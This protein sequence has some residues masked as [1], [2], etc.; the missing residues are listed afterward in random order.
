MGMRPRTLNRTPLSRPQD[1]IAFPNPYR[2]RRAKLRRV[3][4]EEL[5]VHN[6]GSGTGAD[7]GGIGGQASAEC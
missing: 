2:F 1:P 7:D 4:P 3:K 5:R 6:G